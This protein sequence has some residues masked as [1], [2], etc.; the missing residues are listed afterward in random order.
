[1]SLAPEL[2]AD[3]LALIQRTIPLS[4]A[5]LLDL[6]CGDGAMTRRLAAAGARVIGAEADAAAVARVGA[7]IDVIEARA[8]DLP[9]AVASFDAVLMLKSLHHVPVALMPQ[10]LAEVARVLRPGGLLFC[11]EPVF[12]GPLNDIMRLFH[13]EQAERRAALAALH[14][15]IADGTLDF[16]DERI[17]R[18]RISFAGFEDF[19]RR[20]LHLP[21]LRQKVEGDLLDAVH[22]AWNRLGQPRGGKF[23]RLMR[24]TL[25]ERPNN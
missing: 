9:F 21:T 7:Q 20:M 25:A 14:D 22:A 12:A 16:V 1:M 2:I 18:T 4:G 8:E 10:A 13:D 19:Q 24:L 6:G 23:E 15:V 17:Y 5:D 3:E 11:W